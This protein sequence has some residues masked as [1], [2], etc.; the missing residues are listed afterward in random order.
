VAF[1]DEL[2]IESSL[3]SSS[4]IYNAPELHCDLIGI[5]PYYFSYILV[6]PHPELSD[7][8]DIH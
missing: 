8:I 6:S 3:L 2:M 5:S 4:H 1:F 7:E